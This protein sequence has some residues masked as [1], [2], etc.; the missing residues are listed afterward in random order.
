VGWQR[1]W[2]VALTTGAR[3]QA[4][5]NVMD[6]ITHTDARPE[7]SP[8]AAEV[9]AAPATVAGRK[10]AVELIGTFLFLFTIAASVL[11]ASTLAPLA[12]GAA[13]MVMIY[14]G[15]HISGGHYNPAV[16]LAALVRGRI[17]VAEAIGYWIAQLIGGLLAMALARWVI[18]P[19]QVSTLTLS[20]H[21]LSAAFIAELLFTFALC[22]VMLNVA[23]SKDHPTNSP[24]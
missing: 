15:G 1:R 13:L 8:V 19:A 3:G 22:Y 17:G 6:I 21:Q 7:I 20:G 18:H 10:Y 14:A 9:G 2:A 23:T 4:T 24:W 12:I 16:T 11:S 5:L